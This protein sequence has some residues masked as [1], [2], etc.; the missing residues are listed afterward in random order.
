MADRKKGVILFKDYFKPFFDSNIIFNNYSAYRPQYSY[1]F[2]DVTVINNSIRL[3]AEYLIDNIDLPTNGSKLNYIRGHVGNYITDLSLVFFEYF[4][5]TIK[6]TTNNQNIYTVTDFNFISQSLCEIKFELSVSTLFPHIVKDEDSDIPLIY[7]QPNP[8]NITGDLKQCKFIPKVCKNRLFDTTAVTMGASEKISK[9]FADISNFEYNEIL[10]NEF[11]NDNVNN[12]IGAIISSSKELETIM[13]QPV[14]GAEPLHWDEI[15]NSNGGFVGDTYYK[16]NYY[17]FSANA[18]ILFLARCFNYDYFACIKSLSVFPT[19][20]N[21]FP[22][23]AGD[24]F[25]KLSSTSPVPTVSVTLDSSFNLFN[26]TDT[27]GLTVYCKS[28]NA[29]KNSEIRFT[30]FSGIEHIYPLKNWNS[31]KTSVNGFI[32]CKFKLTFNPINCTYVFTPLNYN[33]ATNKYSE[34]VQVNASL[35]G[36]Y[37]SNNLIKYLKKASQDFI[38]GQV[39]YA[40]GL[41]QF[42]LVYLDG[43]S[44]ANGS[45]SAYNQDLSNVIGAVSGFTEPIRKFTRFYGETD[46]YLDNIIPEN[47]VNANYYAITSLLEILNNYNLSSGFQSNFRTGLLQ[48]KDSLGDL[49]NVPTAGNDFTVFIE[50][51]TVFAQVSFYCPTRYSLLNFYDEISLK[52][53]PCSVRFNGNIIDLLNRE[54]MQNQYSYPTNA[55][56]SIAPDYFPFNYVKIDNAKISGSILGL[57]TNYKELMDILT[58]KLA[59]GVFIVDVQQRENYADETPYFLAPNTPETLLTPFGF[60]SVGY[61]GITPKSL[62]D[63]LSSYTYCGS[64]SE[65][66]PIPNNINYL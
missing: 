16:T 26:L 13:N 66:I 10:L 55:Q 22:F 48:A 29:F 42:D 51:L 58:T 32:E 7:G 35:G 1:V 39:S 9:R 33:G 45:N 52:G 30:D 57:Y 40:N 59:D 61:G 36:D 49:F 23:S 37:F 63:L 34:S 47:L 62:L 19:Y 3:P 46:T 64:A 54:G 18:L 20:S 50:G 43:V 44:V 21:T 24:G 14:S 53:L 27:S 4:D 25:I 31:F 65:N 12:H 38:S 15:P 8:L 2:Y 60:L 41:S 11:K 6:Y 28:Y 5:K 17:Y 56:Q